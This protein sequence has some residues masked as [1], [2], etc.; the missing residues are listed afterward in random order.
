MCVRILLWAQLQASFEGS[1]PYQG[2]LRVSFWGNKARLGLLRPLWGHEASSRSSWATQAGRGS[3][4]MGLCSHS[5]YRHSSNYF[6]AVRD[7]QARQC[8]LQAGVLLSGRRKDPPA[9]RASHILIDSSAA[10]RRR[11]APPALARVAWPCS[12]LLPLITISSPRWRRLESFTFT[13]MCRF[14]FARSPATVQRSSHSGERKQK[15]FLGR[16]RLL[17]TEKN[18]R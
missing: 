9:E 8:A 17:G 1:R 13:D 11:V 12:Q 16:E 18:N 3:A 7:D 2:G 6:P 4:P 15:G 14:P 5:K 10:Q